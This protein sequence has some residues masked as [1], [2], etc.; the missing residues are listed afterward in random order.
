MTSKIQLS[1][2]HT[3]IHRLRPNCTYERRNSIRARNS[4][5]DDRACDK[6]AI[7][8]ALLDTSLSYTS[9][10]AFLLNQP[11]IVSAL[12]HVYNLSHTLPV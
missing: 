5:T 9:L 6:V 3:S 8:A 2:F 1:S 10:M 4:N 7:L 12:I 11:F